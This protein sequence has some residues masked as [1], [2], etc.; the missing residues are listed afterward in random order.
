MR[1]S[2]SKD[3]ILEPLIRRALH[4]RTPL[5]FSKAVPAQ[6]IAGKASSAKASASKASA[7]SNSVKVQAGGQALTGVQV[8]FYFS[9]S[10]SYTTV[11][12]DSQG[13]AT[14]NVPAGSHVAMVEPIPNSGFWIMLTDAPASGSTIDCLPIAGGERRWLVAFRDWR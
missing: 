14:L 2:L 5:A 9:G 12:T 7:S 6:A 1:T 8:M 11:T 10:G 4:R 13:V 3:V